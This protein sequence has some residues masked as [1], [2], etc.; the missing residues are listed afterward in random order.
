MWK[1]SKCGRTFP[2]KTKEH[3]CVKISADSHFEGKPGTL[4][5][6]YDKIIDTVSDFGKISIQPVKSGI[7][8]R[9]AGTFAMIA[10]KKDHLKIEFFLDHPHEA[11]PVEKVFQYTQKKYV[12]LVSVS[13]PV[14]VDRQ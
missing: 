11:F 2:L 7:F 10:V 1:C 8:L 4:R 3:S 13:K 14:D 9:K 12:H 5:K 6:T